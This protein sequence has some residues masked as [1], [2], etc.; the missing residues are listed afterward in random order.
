[1]LNNTLDLE[2]IRDVKFLQSGPDCK[3]FVASFRV[4]PDL[5]FQIL[6]GLGFHLHDVLP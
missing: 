4:E 3:E 1:M 6:H 2:I 5:A